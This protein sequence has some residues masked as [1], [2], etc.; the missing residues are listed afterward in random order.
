MRRLSCFA[1]LLI[2]FVVA[3][4]PK[5]AVNSQTAVPTPEATMAA[6]QNPFPGPHSYMMVST[7]FELEPLL[8]DYANLYPNIDFS[9]YQVV[10]K[11]QNEWPDTPFTYIVVFSPPPQYQYGLHFWDY[12]DAWIKLHPGSK[13]AASAT[14][15]VFPRLNR[16]SPYSQFLGF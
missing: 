16:Q 9:S 12:V 10:F 13:A 4:L 8:A 7:N 3:L 14:N 11:S 2:L 6:I 15:N 5:I 1:T